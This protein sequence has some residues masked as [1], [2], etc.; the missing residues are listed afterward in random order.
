MGL[1]AVVSCHYAATVSAEK[2][3]LLRAGVSPEEVAKSWGA[4]TEKVER[5]T[6]RESVWYYARS[7]AYF[8]EGKLVRWT[9]QGEQGLEEYPEVEAKPVQAAASNAQQDG[10]PQENVDDLLSEIMKDVPSEPDSGSGAAG[11]PQALPG[12][13]VAP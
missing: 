10:L 13:S 8:A 1:L 2:L 12:V 9:V 11:M 7:T 6:K 3:P 5:E 4:P